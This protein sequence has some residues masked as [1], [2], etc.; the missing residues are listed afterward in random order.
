MLEEK[1]KALEQKLKGTE[2]IG[3]KD[4][5]KIHWDKDEDLV[6]AFGGN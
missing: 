2:E 5:P 1:V 4:M 3:P 6:R